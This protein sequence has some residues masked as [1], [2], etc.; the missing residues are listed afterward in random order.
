MSFDDR[1][2]W[3]LLGCVIGFFA[4]YVTKSFRTMEAIDKKLDEVEEIVIK[5]VEQH[6][7]RNEQGFFQNPIGSKLALLIVIA[8]TVFAAFSSQKATNDV[9]R[10]QGNITRIS[11][12]NQVYLSRVIAAVNERT[13][14]TRTQV[15]AN[16]A[17]QKAQAEMLAILIKR[18][19]VSDADQNSAIQGYFNALTKFV[20][21]NSNYENAAD[22][23]PYPTDEDFTACIK[24]DDKEK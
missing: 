14:Y 6:R 3:L 10:A 2:F 1:L 13:T 18:P 12:C 15:T 24:A 4:G 17:L 16:V 21:A 11:Y 8:L 9:T 5:D 19:P 7:Q 22:A 23:N 20:Q